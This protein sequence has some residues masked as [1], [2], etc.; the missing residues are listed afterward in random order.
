MEA[1]GLGLF[2][3]AACTFGV[4]LEHPASALRQAIARPAARRAVMGLAMGL[5]A[6]ALIYSPWGRRSGAH[7]NPAVTLAFWRLGKIAGPDALG[8]VAAQFIGGLSGVLLSRGLLG[9]R[10]AAREVGWVATAPG[11][12]GVR[13]AFAAELSISFLL[14]LT[15]LMVSGSSWAG[16]TGVFA[17]LLVAIFIAFE[18]PLSGMSMN[19]ART[20]A[21]A[22][23]ARMWRAIWIYFTAPVAGMLLA[24]AV[25]PHVAGSP[26]GCA[27]LHHD[28]GPCIFRCALAELVRQ[29]AAG[30]LVGE[31]EEER[32]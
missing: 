16:W 2:M 21:S 15:V 29:P 23:P 10:L 25:H 5:T 22:A 30:P 17:G 20:V 6:I 11:P 27:K 7:L 12:R 13:I 31:V 14:M 28:D 9:R 19:P 32:P 24:T 8:Y 18:A 4:L 1:L 3:L 26:A